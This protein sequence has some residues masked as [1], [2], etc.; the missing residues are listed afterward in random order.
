MNAHMRRKLAKLELIRKSQQPK[1]EELKIEEKVTALEPAVEPVKVEEVKAIE[2]VAATPVVVEEA[3]V[4]APVVSSGKK[5]KS[6]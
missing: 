5:K 1:I 4:A 2:E 6:I 3:P